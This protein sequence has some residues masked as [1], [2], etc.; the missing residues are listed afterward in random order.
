MHAWPLG[1][2]CCGVACLVV[3]PMRQ[4][5]LLYLPGPDRKKNISIMY[6]VKSQITRVRMP[7][8]PLFSCQTLGKLLCCP[9]PR[10]SHLKLGL[11][12][13]TVLS[14]LE[15]PQKQM[16]RQGFGCVFENVGKRCSGEEVVG[17]AAPNKWELHALGSA[18]WCLKR[19]FLFVLTVE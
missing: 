12:R 7:T 9:T 6:S 4:L 13:I 17:S 14:S 15:F 16:P 19:W 3:S 5:F 10:F 8:L 11:M 1:A 2:Q 18:S